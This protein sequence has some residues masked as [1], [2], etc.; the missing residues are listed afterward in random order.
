MYINCH[1][2]NF[3]KKALALQHFLCSSLMWVVVLVTVFTD[4]RPVAFLHL[5]SDSKQLLIQ[6]SLCK[7]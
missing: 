4:H 2:L 7:I 6:W 3:E 1:Q 5:M